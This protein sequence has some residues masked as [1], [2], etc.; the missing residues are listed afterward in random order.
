MSVKRASEAWRDAKAEERRRLAV[1]EIT[2][3]QCYMEQLFPD[4]FIDRTDALL[5]GFAAQIAGTATDASAYPRIM[6]QIESL[7]L[8]LNQVNIDFNGAVIETGERED[9]CA[10]ID[11]VL[12]EHGIDLDALA[13]AHGCTADELTDQWREW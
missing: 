9:L 8:A 1:G 2:P 4:A 7:V 13:A 12:V 6:A 5:S 3:A 10:Y 11:A